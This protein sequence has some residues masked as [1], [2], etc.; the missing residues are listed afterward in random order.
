MQTNLRQDAQTPISIA[1]HVVFSPQFTR[2]SLHFWA[3][4]YCHFLSLCPRCC[5]TSQG[6]GLSS[7]RVVYKTF[8]HMEIYANKSTSFLSQPRFYW[9]FRIS[10][11]YF[12]EALCPKMASEQAVSC[13]LTTRISFDMAGSH[14]HHWRYNAIFQSSFV[15]T[16]V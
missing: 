13:R 16:T 11:Q 5:F 3:F 12:N 9:L 15:K 14:L 7:F 4:H 6:S 1:S 8:L 2:W 10:H